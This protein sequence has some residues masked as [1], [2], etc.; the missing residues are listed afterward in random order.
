M[1]RNADEHEK[2]GRQ[3]TVRVG[4]QPVDEAK[5]KKAGVTSAALC[6]IVGISEETSYENKKP[7]R[8]RQQS[9]NKRC[10]R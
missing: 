3:S 7:T 2:G 9:S 4:H 6:M 1:G 10:Q 8:D 5:D